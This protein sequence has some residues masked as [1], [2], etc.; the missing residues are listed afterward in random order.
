MYSK[1]VTTIILADFA[2]GATA[3][4]TRQHLKDTLS[5][6]PALNTIYTHRHSI[7][8]EQ[9]V[10]ELQRQQERDITKE[11]NSEVRMK[12]RNELLKILVPLR[13][14]ILTKNLSINQ[15][16][17]KHVIELVDPDNPA[18]TYPQVE[19]QAA[20]RANIIPP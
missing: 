19:V 10:D 6:S 7:T 16:E 5:I 18:Q 1:E 8:T 3:E 15:S 11:Q 2:R 12:Y 14:E 4:E 13:A 17:V 20:R 9:L